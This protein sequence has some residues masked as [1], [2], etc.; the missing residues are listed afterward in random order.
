MILSRSFTHDMVGA[1]STDGYDPATVYEVAANVR[2]F[3]APDISG[4]PLPFTYHRWQKEV[5]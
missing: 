5:V 4:D 2:V 3:L 1:M